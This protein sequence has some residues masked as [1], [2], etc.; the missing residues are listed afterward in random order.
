M[1]YTATGNAVYYTSGGNANYNYSAGSANYYPPN[2]VPATSN[3]NASYNMSTGGSAYG[4]SANDPQLTPNSYS[5]YGQGPVNTGYTYSAGYNTWYRT[6]TYQYY[7]PR[8]FSPGNNANYNSSNQNYNSSTANYNASNRVYN[9]A[10]PGT[11]GN[12]TITYGGYNVNFAKSSP[13][14][15][16]YA[17]LYA[18]LGANG[19]YQAYTALYNA[20]VPSPAYVVSPA[21]LSYQGTILKSAAMPANY[22]NSPYVNYS[23][24]YGT[25]PEQATNT[26]NSVSLANYNA[27]YGTGSYNTQNIANYNAPNAYWAVNIQYNV[28]Y[29][30]VYDST[31]FTQLGNVSGNNN[32]TYPY[33]NTNA[34]NYVLW[35]YNTNYPYWYTNTPTYPYANTNATNYPY[36]NTNATNYPYANTNPTNYPY[37]NT[38]PTITNT[39]PSI[40]VSGVTLPGGYGGTAPTVSDTLVGTYPKYGTTTSVTVP[41]GGYVTIKFTL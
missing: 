18:Y 22:A 29:L 15:T 40:T 35:Y 17:S 31:A 37:A 41:T 33:A 24:V 6:T 12:I 9:A 16:N 19:T 7:A 34:I 32:P 30:T 28:Q 4:S 38:N 2:Y 36:A 14:T 8:P 5:T 13:Y 27:S 11:I 20:A 25:I 3:S 26:Y 23:T 21:A 1:Y 10:T 39:G